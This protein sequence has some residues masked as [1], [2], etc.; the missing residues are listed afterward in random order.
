MEFAF[1]NPLA[2]I[3][4]AWDGFMALIQPVIDNVINP[5]I[6]VCKKLYDPIKKAIMWAKTNIIDPVVNV[7]MEIYK[8][9]MWFVNWIIK[10]L[11]END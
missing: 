1:I 11:Y 10:L 2:A 9:I 4:C 7:I 6:E 3:C 5:F 8:A